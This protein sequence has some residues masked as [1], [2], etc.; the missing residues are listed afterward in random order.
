MLGNKEETDDKININDS[1]SIIDTIILNE[2]KD[3][4]KEN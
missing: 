4:Q 3:I 1:E 2:L